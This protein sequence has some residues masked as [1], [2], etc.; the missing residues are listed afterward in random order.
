MEL[1]QEIIC[2]LLNFYFQSYIC[3]S[4]SFSSFAS[5]VWDW[6]KVTLQRSQSEAS[7]VARTEKPLPSDLEVARPVQPLILGWGYNI[8]SPSSEPPRDL[9]A[10]KFN[11]FTIFWPLN[12]KQL[13]WKNHPNLYSSTEWPRDFN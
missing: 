1:L 5:L 7:F 9:M 13:T 11:L 4:A 6:A 3:S 2:W 12:L 8:L 10:I